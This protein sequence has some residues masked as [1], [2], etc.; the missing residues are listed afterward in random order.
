[1]TH[2][3]Q[4]PGGDHRTERGQGEHWRTASWPQDDGADGAAIITAITELASA[5]LC[6]L[7][8]GACA[9]AL[10]LTGEYTKTRVQF[11]RPIATFQAVMA[12]GELMPMH[13]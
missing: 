3:R 1:M 13:V 6:V 9:T 5:A 2:H 4:P 11:D 10:S 7:E 12:A 8:A